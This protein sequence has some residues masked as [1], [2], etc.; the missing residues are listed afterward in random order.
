MVEAISRTPA[1]AKS[2]ARSSQR[3]ASETASGIAIIQRLFTHIEIKIS[4]TSEFIRIFGKEVKANKGGRYSECRGHTYERF[5]H[6]ALDDGGLELAQRIVQRFPAFN[7]IGRG[8]RLVQAGSFVVSALDY[9]PSV[10]HG[11]RSSSSTW[12]VYLPPSRTVQTLQQFAE[13]LERCCARAAADRIHNA[14]AVGILGV[15]KGCELFS[16]DLAEYLHL[17]K[18]VRDG[19]SIGIER[20]VLRECAWAFN[21]PVRHYIETLSR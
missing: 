1:E 5:V 20:C 11:R 2:V 12:H 8:E 3:A 18:Q 19:L 16:R 21:G 10:G 14:I 7:V 6:L 17:R 9:K 13:Y 4:S 15:N